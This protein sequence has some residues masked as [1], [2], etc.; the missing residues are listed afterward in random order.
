MSTGFV[1]M[2][3]SLP[4]RTSGRSRRR[5]ERS[6]DTARRNGCVT[7]PRTSVPAGT[8]TFAPTGHPRRSL[9]TTRSPDRLVADEIAVSRTRG[10]VAP[11]GR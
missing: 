6:L 5:G 4:L 7:R 11:S 3:Y 8:T 9:A 1:P 2:E 10:N